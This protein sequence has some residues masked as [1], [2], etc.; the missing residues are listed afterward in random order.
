VGFTL[1]GLDKLAAC[2]SADNKTNLLRYF[3]DQLS[4]AH[5]G[6]VD[7][8]TR[9]MSTLSVASK[10][11]C[12]NIDSEFSKLQSGLDACTQSLHV[13]QEYTDAQ[14]FFRKTKLKIPYDV[15]ETLA[16][17]VFACEQEY[18]MAHPVDQSGIV[19]LPFLRASLPKSMF[20]SMWPN[21][22]SESAR[23]EYMPYASHLVS[24]C[25]RGAKAKASKG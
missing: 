7:A 20:L 15:G 18:L 5:P 4:L 23:D 9:S 24:L 10:V 3:L 19:Q 6:F 2:K 1:D 22:A 14:L 12:T 8:Y 11:Q 16:D 25:V 13:M 17:C 21:F